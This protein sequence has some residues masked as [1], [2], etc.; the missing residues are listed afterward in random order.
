M[1]ACNRNNAHVHAC[2]QDAVA[3]SGLHAN[4]QDQGANVFL[5]EAVT[6]NMGIQTWNAFS[7]DHASPQPTTHFGQPRTLGT[8]ALDR[9]ASPAATYGSHTAPPYAAQPRGLLGNAGVLE[10]SPVQVPQQAAAMTLDEAIGHE[11]ESPMTSLG[12][13]NGSLRGKASGP[14]TGTGTAGAADAAATAATV[15]MAVP[16]APVHGRGGAVGGQGQGG[17]SPADG[18]G[19]FPSNRLDA[20]QAN[21][22]RLKQQ[23][24]ENLERQRGLDAQ[25]EAQ[26]HKRRSL[27]LEGATWSPKSAGAGADADA[28]ASV[29]TSDGPES[30]ANRWTPNAPAQQPEGYIQVGGEADGEAAFDAARK[31]LQR[32]RSPAF[33]Q[34]GSA[35]TVGVRVQDTAD[36]SSFAAD[37]H[38]KRSASLE[39]RAGGPAAAVAAVAAVAAADHRYGETDSGSSDSDSDYGGEQAGGWVNESLVAPADEAPAGAEHAFGGAATAEE[40]DAA[41]KIQA[42]FRGAQVRKSITEG[43]AEAAEAA[44]AAAASEEAEAAT[45]IQAVFRG[46]Q[47]RQSLASAREDAGDGGQGHAGG[48]EDAEDAA[49]ASDD[50]DDDDDT[51]AFVRLQAK[52]KQ[53]REAGLGA[54][55][56][57]VAM[58]QG[59]S[60]EARDLATYVDRAKEVELSFD[61]I[62]KQKAAR[63]KA[64]SAA[65]QE[66]KRIAREQRQAATAAETARHLAEETARRNQQEAAAAAA[67]QREREREEREHVAMLASMST[68]QKKIYLERRE[69]EQR[70]KEHLAAAQSH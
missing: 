42:V 63:L 51:P 64:E 35:T 11:F 14:G 19:H 26:N 32:S 29:N 54:G 7:P 50:D 33:M 21:L 36:L 25:V 31:E 52:L 53:D 70:E 6:A 44:E 46:R 18:F 27:E 16:A 1:H 12:N 15:R 34:V 55:G 28:N 8:P 5:K 23:T 68:G 38:I 17:G 49:E 22:D 45:K 10:P 59:S 58:D 43:Q 48:A 67:A 3:N 41:A 69:Q 13:I 65:N 60:G 39:K 40:H 4:L 24:L 30:Q 66:A 2:S 9:T 61:E 62:M 56:A 37:Y 20:I 57:G 47:A